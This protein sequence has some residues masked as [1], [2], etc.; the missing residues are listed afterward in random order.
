VF[1][2]SRFIENPP[3]DLEVADPTFL[4]WFYH[5][6]GLWLSKLM[7]DENG[8]LCG[9]GRQSVISYIHGE[10]YCI[11]VCVLQASVE[12]IL[13]DLVAPV[14]CPAFIAQDVAVTL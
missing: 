1:A 2:H 6:G 12:L 7:Q 4:R 10:N 11:V 3:I 9:S 13:M 14:I 8:G 5:N